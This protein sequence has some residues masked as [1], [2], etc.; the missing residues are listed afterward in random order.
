MPSK[1]PNDGKDHHA[2]DG[3]GGVLPVQIGAGAFL[4]RRCNFLH[5]G[6]AGPCRKD[7]PA[8]NDPIQNRQQATSDDQLKCQ[9]HKNFPSKD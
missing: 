8:G 7:R 4:N 1:Y 9:A 3:D 5:P 6:I 2:N